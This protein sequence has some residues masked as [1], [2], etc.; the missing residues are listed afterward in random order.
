LNVE[1]RSASTDAVVADLRPVETTQLS[2]NFSPLHSKPPSWLP[3]TGALHVVQR[4]ALGDTEGDVIGE[5]DGDIKG[6][7]DGDAECKDAG[8]VL[9]L[10]D[11]DTDGE[12]NDKALDALKG[13]AVRETLGD[14]VSMPHVGF[15]SLIH[16]TP[17]LLITLHVRSVSELLI[18]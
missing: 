6:D 14:E 17:P 10:A 2:A 7:A 11:G 1:A 12:A 5:L 15:T 9:G 4:D 8:E 16:V 13:E 18:T 3:R